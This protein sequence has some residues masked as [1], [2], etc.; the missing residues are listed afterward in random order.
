[1]IDLKDYGIDIWPE[2]KIADFRRTLLNWYDQEKGICLGA[3][4]K[5][6]ITSGFQKLCYSRL[7]FRQLSLTI[8]V[9]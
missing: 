4:P 3:E 5:T 2:D 6:L 8:T 1:M 7:K 9:F